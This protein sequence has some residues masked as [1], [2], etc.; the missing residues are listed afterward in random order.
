MTSASSLRAPD[1][2]ADR[3]FIFSL[4]K[5]EVTLLQ[6]MKVSDTD[7]RP[8]WCSR[9]L[10]QTL[11]SDRPLTGTGIAWC[12]LS[13]QGVLETFAPHQMS[14][15][16]GSINCLFFS[17]CRE[18]SF[19]ATVKWDLAKSLLLSHTEIIFLLV[20]DFRSFFRPLSDAFHSEKQRE[21]TR[22]QK[23]VLL[24]SCRRL[25]WIKAALSLFHA[26]QGSSLSPSTEEKRTFTV[27]ISLLKS[28][29]QKKSQ[30]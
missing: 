28:E 10:S 1:Q 25:L 21:A 27:F 18:Y 24:G 15:L 12:W 6:F 19:F 14:H 7:Q 3:C 5:A 22:R 29:T 9:P 8:D 4:Q 16:S 11:Q 20:G 17:L 13:L 23:K 30:T 26:V 2:T